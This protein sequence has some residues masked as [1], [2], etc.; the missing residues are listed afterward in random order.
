VNVISAETPPLTGDRATVTVVARQQSGSLVDA[1]GKVT[2]GIKAAGPSD[3]EVELRWNGGEWRV[4]KI[5]S[6]S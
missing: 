6:F 1:D 3:L 4:S 5:T 2:R